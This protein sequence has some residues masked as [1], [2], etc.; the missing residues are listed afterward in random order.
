VGAGD[1]GGEEEEGQPEI[2]SEP[3][4]P[5]SPVQTRAHKQPTVAAIRS[6]GPS[7]GLGNKISKAAP[8]PSQLDPYSSTNAPVAHVCV[9]VGTRVS[10]PTALPAPHYVSSHIIKSK[11]RRTFWAFL[12]NIVRC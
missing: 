10:F 8:L 4:A 5:F 3:R 7:Q 6:F 9:Y 11:L 2:P 1:E 12:G